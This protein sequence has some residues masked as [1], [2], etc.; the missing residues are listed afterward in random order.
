MWVW[1]KK[2][3]FHGNSSTTD[4]IWCVKLVKLPFKCVNETSQR[5]HAPV[6]TQTVCLFSDKRVF[7]HAGWSQAWSL[8]TGGVIPVGMPGARR[9][10]SGG[11]G[12]P[13][14]EFITPD[15]RCQ[16]DRITPREPLGAIDS[17]ARLYYGCHVA[18]PPSDG[19][20]TLKFCW[21]QS[22]EFISSYT[23]PRSENMGTT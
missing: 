22:A 4:F 1:T 5:V 13:L 14:V 6:N 16:G 19:M 12:C 21:L 18:D 7:P 10:V 23:P 9:F 15:G 17:L 3:Q 11:A 8:Y 20:P 2:W